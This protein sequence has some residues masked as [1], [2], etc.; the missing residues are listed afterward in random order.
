M[1]TFFILLILA[2]FWLG[3]YQI[4]RGSKVRRIFFK[5]NVIVLIVYLIFFIVSMYTWDDKGFGAYLF[6]GYVLIIHTVILFIFSLMSLV[7]KK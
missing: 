3:S 2:L 1:E 5:T 7:F 6:F 4:L